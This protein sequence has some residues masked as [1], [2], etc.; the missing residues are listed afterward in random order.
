MSTTEP[1]PDI[2]GLTFEKTWAMLQ[3]SIRK[4][5]L[6]SEQMKRHD[7]YFAQMNEKNAQLDALFAKTEAQMAETAAKMTKTEALFAETAAQMARTDA[8]MARTDER[9][10]RLGNRFGDVIEHLVKPGVIERFNELGYSF[11]SRTEN[12][13]VFD[14]ATKKTLTELDII[15]ENGES[16]IVIEVKVTA[17]SN[18]IQK[19]I[20]KMQI[21]R[22][23]RTRE[24][25]LGNKK[26]YGGIAAGV[27]PNDI[28][29]AALEAG[30]YVIVQ[31]GDTVKIDV[32]EG[33]VPTAF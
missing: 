27:F 10:G 26:L 12:F 6:L 13:A 2:T 20:Q 16:I 24:M 7:E 8:Q 4:S 17:S 3:E 11:N 14:P 9:L 33:F 1:H 23:F 31:S 15:L 30:F 21:Y 32:P 25:P 5:E 22:A 19:H 29:K 18:D 28:Q